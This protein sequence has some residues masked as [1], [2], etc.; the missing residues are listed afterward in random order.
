[1]DDLGKVSIIIVSYND[2]KFIVPCLE[3]LMKTTVDL[4]YE[5]VIVD[6]HSD[7]PTES[8]VSSLD[9]PNLRVFRNEINEGFARAV[10]R[11]LSAA[12]GD[13]YLL[14][15]S[16]TVVYQGCVAR[17]VQFLENH[18]DGSCVGPLIH[19]PNGGIEHSTHG[20]PTLMKEF[21]HALPVLKTLFHYKGLIGKLISLLP[22]KSVG[23]GSMG[24]YWNYDRVKVVDNITGAC[25]MARKKAVDEVGSMDPNFWLYSEEID[26]NLRFKKAGW[27]VYFTPEAEIL[28]YFGQSTGQKPRSQKVNH[29]LIERYRGMIYFYRK[30]YGELKTTLLRIIYLCAFTLRIVGAFMKMPFK[31]I[32]TFGRKIKVFSHILKISLFGPLT[33]TLPIKEIK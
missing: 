12:T 10:N 22:T 24:S 20:F 13:Y 21:F 15:N 31:G 8:V 5:I 30:H 6:N 18:P 16:D 11:G 1:M 17:M 2:E 3:S 33:P 19:S 32:E 25:L 23:R 4:E 29:V 26:W 14:L 7:T 9:L 28:H 27:N